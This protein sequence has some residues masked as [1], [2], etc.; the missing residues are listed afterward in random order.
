MKTKIDQIIEETNNFPES[1]FMFRINKLAKEA[2]IDYDQLQSKLD[3]LREKTIEVT[4]PH[5]IMLPEIS[6]K[7]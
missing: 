5:T 7:D 2:K 3:Y 4:N 1:S 6:N